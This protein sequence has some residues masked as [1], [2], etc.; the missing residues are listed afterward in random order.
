MA[1]CL[2][3][4]RFKSFLVWLD[5]ALFFRHGSRLGGFKDSKGT[6]LFFLTLVDIT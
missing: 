5:L 2:N 1:F 3:Q 6:D 4:L